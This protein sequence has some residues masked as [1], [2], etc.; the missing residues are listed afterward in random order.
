MILVHVLWHWGRPDTW[1]TPIGEAVS[2]AAGPT[3]APVFTFLMGASLAF[4]APTSSRTLAVRGLWLLWLGYVL[5]VFRGALPAALGLATGVVTEQQIEPFTPWWLLTSV[6]LHHV[7]GLSLVVVAGLLAIS[8]PN[9]WWLALGA[10]AVAIAP[11]ARQLEVGTPLLDA[12]LTPILGSAP[13]VY[14]ALV[15]WVVYPLAGAV[16]G[17]LVARSTD[18]PRAFRRAG[19]VGV[20]FLA[21]GGALLA[22]EQPSFDVFTYWRQPASFVV[23]IVGVV[24]AWLWLCDVVSRRVRLERVFAVVYD[25]SARLLAMY[26]THWLIVG[27]GVG[28]VGFRA[29]PL[30]VVL[31]AMAIAVAATSLLSRWAVHLETAPWKWLTRRWA[32]ASEAA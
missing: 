21:A 4:A 16:F 26:F 17:D 30:E 23:A 3:A 19:L 9:R 25:W 22:L 12:P 20:G 14:Y 27:W 10:G 15:P 18:R 11:L 5:N 8:R 7:T 1:A 2:F 13:N 29:L 31:P 28:L 24:L 6:D 32:G